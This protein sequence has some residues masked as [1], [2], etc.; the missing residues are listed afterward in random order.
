M[1]RFY[2]KDKITWKDIL[3]DF[4]LENYLFILFILIKFYFLFHF[5]WNGITQSILFQI[6]NKPVEDFR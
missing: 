2:E 5:W 1:I 6:I 4:L 3:F